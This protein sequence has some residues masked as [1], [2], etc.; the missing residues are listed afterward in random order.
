MVDLE[1]LLHHRPC[2][3]NHGEF[4]YDRKW[5]LSILCRVRGIRDCARAS[6]VGVGAHNSS[7]AERDKRPRHSAQRG[8]VRC[9]KRRR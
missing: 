3:R 5:F 8:F 7:K 1:L 2:H 9:L 6:S 4:A